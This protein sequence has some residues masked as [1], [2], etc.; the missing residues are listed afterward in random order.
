M[1]YLCRLHDGVLAVLTT[2]V[3][4]AYLCRLHDGVLA[5]N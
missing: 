3:P 5:E 2:F 1:V 4:S